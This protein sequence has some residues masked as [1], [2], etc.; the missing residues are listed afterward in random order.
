MISYFDDDLKWAPF[1]TELKEWA[2]TPYRHLGHWKGRGAD[3]T[4]YLATALKNAGIL[5]QTKYEYYSRD[6]HIH[7][8]DELVVNSYLSNEEYLLPGLCFEV[9]DGV[10]E[11]S[12]RGDFLMMSLD[13][14]KLIHHAAVLIADNALMQC[15][16]ARGVV[17]TSFHD[18]WKRHVRRT[19]RIVYKEQ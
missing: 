4:L 8:T 14:A 5:T 7:G 12:V 3:C 15:I 6:W 13:G 9:T 2:G 18:W 17:E 10:P 19:V 16:P 1:I 11:T